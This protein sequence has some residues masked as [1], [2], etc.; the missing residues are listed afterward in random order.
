MF[1]QVTCPTNNH[2]LFGPGGTE[3]IIP[4]VNT[5]INATRSTTVPIDAIYKSYGK[6]KQ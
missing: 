4:G 5:I 3:T 2:N 6:N 1:F